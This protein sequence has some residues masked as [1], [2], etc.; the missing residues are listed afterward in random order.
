MFVSDA[1]RGRD[2]S[3]EIVRALNPGER[4]EIA[5]YPIDKQTLIFF[6]PYVT[7]RLPELWEN[8]EAALQPRNGL[9]K[10]LHPPH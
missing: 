10:T 5:D 7:H 3:N 4:D 1:P 6:C 2:E 9:P 8:P